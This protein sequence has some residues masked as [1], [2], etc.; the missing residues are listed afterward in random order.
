MILALFFFAALSLN[1]LLNFGLGVRE[2]ISRERSPKAHLYYPWVILFLATALIWVVF[3][4]ILRPLGDTFNYLLMIPLALLG[5][6]EIEKLLFYFFPGLGDC[7]GVF[8]IGSAYNDLSAAALFFTLQFALTVWE[9]LLFSCAFSAGGLLAF[10]V[11]KEIQKRSFLEAIPYGLRGT[12]ILLISLGILSLIFSAGA[13]LL[14]KI[15]G[16]GLAR[17]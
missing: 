16:P 7:P 4:R 2:L 11:V 10:L 5:S 15:L 1:L 8:K 14:L 3:A 6:Q 9:A 12:P 17:P 13:V